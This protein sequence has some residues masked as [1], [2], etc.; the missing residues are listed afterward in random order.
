MDNNIFNESNV[1]LNVKVKDKWEA[2]RVCGQILVDQGYVTETYVNDMIAREQGASVYVGNSVAIPHGVAN[3][4]KNIFQSGI[5]FLQVPDGVD[6]DGEIAYLLIGIAGKDGAH[7][8]MLG[9]IAMVCS[10]LDSVERLKKAATEKEICN[11]FSE[12]LA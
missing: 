5:S 9:Q 6:F 4:E 12:L 7:I 1:K 3:S 10:D 8:E 2:I 11:I